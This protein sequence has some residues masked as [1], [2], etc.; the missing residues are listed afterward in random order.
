MANALYNYAKEQFLQAGLNLSSG[1]I[2]AVL[3][4]TADYT[5][6]LST[7]QDLADVPGAARVATSAN[8]SSKTFSAGTFDSADITFSSVTGDQSEAIVLYLDS[9]VEATSTLIAYF[10]TAS[11]GLP[12]TPDGN[13]ITVT[14]NAAGWFTL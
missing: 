10:D 7:D 13:N 1:N 3:V 2:K 9:G 6:N 11:S 8:L 14:V 4:D 12:V 5:V